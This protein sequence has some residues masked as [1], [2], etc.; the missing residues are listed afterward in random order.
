MS[1]AC[2][3]LEEPKLSDDERAQFTWLAG[4]E[5]TLAA[6]YGPFTLAAW[7]DGEEANTIEILLEHAAAGRAL[8]LRIWSRLR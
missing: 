3:G 8:R 7:R 5:T 2:R 6:Q 1:L 4:Y